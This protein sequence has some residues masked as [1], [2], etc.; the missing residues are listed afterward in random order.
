MRCRQT[1]PEPKEYTQPEPPGFPHTRRLG[2]CYLGVSLRGSGGVGTLREW[3]WCS[4]GHPTRP[5]GA[6]ARALGVNAVPSLQLVHGVCVVWRGVTKAR[7]VGQRKVAANQGHA[8]TCVPG[9][10]QSQ[11]TTAR[12][13][14]SDGFDASRFLFPRT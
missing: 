5:L 6:V 13:D 14:R 1:R 9:G 11:K 8:C 3:E 2:G 7:R 12:R 4:R 10:S